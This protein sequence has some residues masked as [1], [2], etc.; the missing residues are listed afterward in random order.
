MH[1]YTLQ[2][3]P[4]MFGVLIDAIFVGTVYEPHAARVVVVA[5]NPNVLDLLGQQVT[6]PKYASAVFDP[7]PRP[8]PGSGHVVYRVILS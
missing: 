6:R 1:P 4:H 2:S 8:N 3:Q 5:Q 7:S